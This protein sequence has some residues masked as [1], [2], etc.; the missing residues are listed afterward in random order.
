[1][2]VEEL[3]DRS[4]GEYRSF[5]AQREFSPVW[6]VNGRASSAGEALL[7][8]LSQAHVD[9]LDS[10]DYDLNQL[11]VLARGA[12]G[13]PNRIAR[14]ELKFMQEFVRYVRDMRRPS[15]DIHYADESLARAPDEGDVLAEAAQARDFQAYVRN[16]EW[17][18]PLYVRLREAVLQHDERAQTSS[19]T[20]IPDGP[21]L[22]PGDRGQ[23]VRLLR[24]RLNLSPGDTFDAD[25]EE[26]LRRFQ[27]SRGLGDDGVAGKRTLAALNGPGDGF[28]A[29]LRVNLDRARPLPGPWTPH[30]LVNAA[31]ARLTYYGD[32]SE[33]GS[34]KVVVGTS[35]TPTPVMA[36]MIQFATLNPYWNVPVSLASKNIA[37]AILRGA[38]LERMGYEALSS[39]DEDARVIDQRS[40]DWKAVAEG[41][42]QVRLR[43]LPSADNA[44]GQMKFI[45]PNDLG[46]YLHDT[47]DRH[48]FAR[49]GR[50]FSNGCVRLEDAERLGEWFFGRS[51][52]ASSGAPEQHV[53]LPKPV[54]VYITYLTAVPSEG[55]IAFTGDVYN[56]DADKLSQLASR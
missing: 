51:L 28:A 31:A 50:Q 15:D 22:R 14:A 25:L 11:R 4:R 47:P 37:P 12:G 52:K 5:Y 44:M 36:G 8:L 24:Q 9:G 39:W 3:R 41:R 32:G 29:L 49:H 16:A 45:F 7:D 2:V 34:M 46:I 53:L 19:V 1:M 20:V 26:A 54:P 56:L 38:S 10:D 40:I 23:R 55:T 27:R 30:V 48:L 33:Q 6:I 43:K 42:E 21:G 17:M 13:D 18:S 35:E